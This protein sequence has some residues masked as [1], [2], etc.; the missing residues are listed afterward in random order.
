MSA[1]YPTKVVLA[2]RSGGICAI[3]G[4]G[5]VL[6]YEATHGTDAYTGEAAHIRGEKS[7]AARYDPAMTEEERNAVENLIYLCADDHTII[8]KVEADWPVFRLMALKAEHEA[9]A[10]ALM[11]EGFASV[12]FPELATA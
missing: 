5:R 11:E 4:C 10:R 8:D 9:K 2:F 3:P 7:K 6:T 1:T 12:A